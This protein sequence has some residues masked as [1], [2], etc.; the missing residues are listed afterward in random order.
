MEE[1]FPSFLEDSVTYQAIIAKGAAKGRTAEAR[2]LLL[3]LGRKKFGVP[4]A[5]TLNILHSLTNLGRLEK[6][7]G[8][9]LEVETWS[10]LLA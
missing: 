9:L 10:E 3:R 8:F 6:L 2:H 5:E 7:L 4:D 1:S